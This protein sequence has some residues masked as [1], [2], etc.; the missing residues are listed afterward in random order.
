MDT[1]ITRSATVA[2]W[3]A[4][5]GARRVSHLTKAERA[6]IRAG[7]TVLIEG[8]PAYRGVTVRRIVERGACFYTRMP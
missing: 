4:D 8:C 2:G 7:G 6:H 5:R 1:L 3:G